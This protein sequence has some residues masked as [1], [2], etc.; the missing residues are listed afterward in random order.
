MHLLG[1][2]IWILKLLMW[3]IGDNTSTI[4][5]IIFYDEITR[6]FFYYLCYNW[7]FYV[8]WKPILR[9][10]LSSY[11]IYVISVTSDWDKFTTFL[12]LLRNYF[13]FEYFI[14]TLFIRVIYGFL[15]WFVFLL[16]YLMSKPTI[17]LWY[18]TLTLIY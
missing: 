6:C 15:K 1:H 7:K 4:F 2:I 9:R 3:L 5:V 17:Y 11:F 10:G 14:E 13:I 12:T 8:L 16:F 18:L